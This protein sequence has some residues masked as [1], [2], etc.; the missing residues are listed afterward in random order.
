MFAQQDASTFAGPEVSWFALSPML[1]LVGVALFLLVV[2]ALTPTWP[3]GWYAIVTAIGAGAAGVL[4]MV[5]WDDVTDNGPSTLVGGALAFDTFAQFITI[6]ICA[7]LDPRRPDERRLPAPGRLRRPRGLR[8]VPGRR[9][10]RGRDGCGERP[11]RAVR[12][13]GDAVAGVLRPGRRATG[14]RRAARRAV[15]STSCSAASRRRSSSTASPS[16]TAP[17]ARRTS[18]RWSRTLSDTVP[19]ERNDALDPGRRRPVARRARRSRSPPCRSTCGRPTSTR[20][21]RRRSPGSWPRSARSPPSPPC[22]ACSSSACR[23]TATT[24]SRRSG[25]SPCCR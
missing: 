15:S 23:S 11:H 16:S 1:V 2:G 20:G 22:C 6:T 17:S 4:S 9:D 25:S 3:K 14:A 12:R 18:R 24:G 10:R 5:L 19:I 21:R 8:P 7:G 13:A